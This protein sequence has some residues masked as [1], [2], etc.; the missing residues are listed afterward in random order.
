MNRYPKTLKELVGLSFPVRASSGFCNQW[1]F[2]LDTDGSRVSR[3]DPRVKQIAVNVLADM[4]AKPQSP[5][6]N[7]I[8]P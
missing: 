8:V 4:G 5:D 2:G 3:E 6:A 7:I 1:M